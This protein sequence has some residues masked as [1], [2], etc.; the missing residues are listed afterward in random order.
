V[1]EGLYAPILIPTRH[2]PKIFPTARQKNPRAPFSSE[3]FTP[4]QNFPVKKIFVRNPFASPRRVF[5]G[6]IDSL[7]KYFQRAAEFVPAF[8][9]ST[10]KVTENLQRLIDFYLTV[11][12]A[13]PIGCGQG[14]GHPHPVVVDNVLES[15]GNFHSPGL[16]ARL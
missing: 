4:P 15:F 6:E 2:S 9:L 11:I 7:R 10:P 14:S 3:N 12:C 5:R 1:W 8:T 16:F 13:I